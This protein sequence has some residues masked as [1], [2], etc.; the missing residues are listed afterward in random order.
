VKRV[1]TA[2]LNGMVDVLNGNY[3]ALGKTSVKRALALVIRGDAIISEN[4]GDGRTI[5]AENLQFP[6]PLVI[7]L[8]RFAN[9]N[10]HVGPAHFSKA[11]VRKRDGGKCAYCGKPGAETVDH[12]Y[13]QSR[14]GKDTWE[15]VITACSRDNAKK[16]NRTPEEAGMPLL[17][18]PTV[19]TRIFLH[20]E[21]TRRSRKPRGH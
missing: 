15:N 6:F 19:P 4:T 2:T 20:G 1:T 21:G 7:R 12:I 8:L 18:Q 10:F 5:R 16:R 17:F 11:G 14:G 13:P 3:L 9:V